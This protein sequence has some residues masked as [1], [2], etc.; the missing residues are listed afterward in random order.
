MDEAIIAYIRRQHNV[1]IGD[2]TAERIKKAIGSACLPDEG[3]GRTMSIKGLTRGVPRDIV[4]S[5]REI[6]QSLA[7]PVGAI[8]DAV[9]AALGETVPELAADIVERGIVL[10]G[11]GALLANLDRVLRYT[12][13]LPVSVAENPSACVALG[14]G[15]ALEQRRALNKVFLAAC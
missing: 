1:L 8:I 11:G 13:G 9:N 12:T 2:D 4:V 3:E 14:T 10:T 15:R 7:E 6:A 5:E